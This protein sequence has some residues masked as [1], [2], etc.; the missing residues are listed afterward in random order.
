MCAGVKRRILN[1]NLRRNGIIVFVINENRISFK[2]TIGSK[3]F[4]LFYHVINFTLECDLL[5]ELIECFGQIR[6]PCV[7]IVEN[8]FT[9]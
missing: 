1:N 5:G 8:I 3:F 4:F 9:S 7:G 6:K 2:T